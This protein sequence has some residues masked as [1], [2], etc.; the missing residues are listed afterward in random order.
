MVLWGIG[1]GAQESIMKA[2]VAGM[3]PPERRGAAFGL[4]TSGY[5]LAW[6]F[7]SAVMGLLYDLSLQSLVIFSVATQGLGAVILVTLLLSS[8][9]SQF[10][11]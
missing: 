6:F 1:M 4:F 5:G 8:T 10:R 11:R 7:G 3:V 9:G 2:A